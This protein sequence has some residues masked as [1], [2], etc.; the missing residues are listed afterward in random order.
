M[1]ASAG[2]AHLDDTAKREW[3]VHTLLALADELAVVPKELHAVPFECIAALHTGNPTEY[4]R[5]PMPRRQSLEHGF[6]A[7]SPQIRR[8]VSDF[9]VPET[10]RTRRQ[11]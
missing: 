8:P 10:E 9:A 6:M 2:G 11:R 5:I 1:E 4:R 7:T 3:A